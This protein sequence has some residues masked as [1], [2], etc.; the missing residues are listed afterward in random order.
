MINSKTI[1]VQAIGLV[2]IILC[3]QTAM[4]EGPPGCL[5]YTSG[6]NSPRT[7][8]N[9]AGCSFGLGKDCYGD[10]SRVLFYPNNPNPII[11][12]FLILSSMLLSATYIHFKINSILEWNYSNNYSSLM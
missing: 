3:M 8:C 7:P 2:T 1:M 5:C 9:T 6:G 11:Y 4:G 12:S 10:V